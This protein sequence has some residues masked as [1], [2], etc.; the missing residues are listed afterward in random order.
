MMEARET[1]HDRAM[2]SRLYKEDSDEP[3]T[4]EWLLSVGGKKGLHVIELPGGTYETGYFAYEVKSGVGWLGWRIYRE[5]DE[6]NEHEVACI[7]TR[8]E[9]RV[10]AWLLGLTAYDGLPKHRHV[11]LGP[12]RAC[13][14]CGRDLTDPL[15]LRASEYGT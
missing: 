15:H 10:A 2:F 8:L 3:V 9:F 4:E 6:G 5:D 11:H 7:H 1:I 13:G 14:R 12:G